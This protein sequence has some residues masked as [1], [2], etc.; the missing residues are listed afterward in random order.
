MVVG[1]FGGKVIKGF[2]RGS[3]ELGFPTAN[4]ENIE[5]NETNLRNGVYYGFAKVIGVD[6][7][8]SMM[9][10]SVGY[11]PFYNNTEKSFE[12]HILK[13]YKI[14]FYG[15]YLQ[16]EIIDFIRNEMNFIDKKQLISEIEND[17]KIC[18][19]NL[20]NKKSTLY[21]ATHDNQDSSVFAKLNIPTA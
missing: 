10:M 21:T 13:Y 4:I 11:N 1:I 9:V 7:E 20:K 6:N 12:V 5:E 3:A 8:P 14:S 2:G 16:I 19:E 18:K 17:I 15:K